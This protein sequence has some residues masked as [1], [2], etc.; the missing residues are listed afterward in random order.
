[1]VSWEDRNNPSLV[2]QDYHELK[3]DYWELVRLAPPDSVTGTCTIYIDG[4]GAV[5]TTELMY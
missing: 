5:L 3:A 1:M 4:S 2:V